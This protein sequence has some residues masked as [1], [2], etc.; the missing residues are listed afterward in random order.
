MSGHPHHLVGGSKWQHFPFCSFAPSAQERSLGAARRKCRKNESLTSII[1]NLVQFLKREFNFLVARLPN[2]QGPESSVE[3]ELC[4]CQEGMDA[5]VMF[6]SHAQR[7]LVRV[8]VMRRVRNC[9]AMKGPTGDC[10]GLVVSETQA[11]NERGGQE[12]GHRAVSAPYRYW[13]LR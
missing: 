2:V 10:R 4:G 11:F 8:V 6:A 5:H 9:P 13:V 3:L 1:A 7:H 12:P